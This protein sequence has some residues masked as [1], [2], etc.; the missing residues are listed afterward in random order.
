MPR[1]LCCAW[2]VLL[3]ALPAAA[4]DAKL[5][6]KPALTL[7]AEVSKQARFGQAL[8]VRLAN[9]GKVAVSVVTAKL[10]LRSDEGD[11]KLT[12]ALEMTRKEMVNSRLVVPP[13][14]SLGIVKLM[15][16]EVA[17]VTV[18]TAPKKLAKLADN[19]VVVT[20]EVSEFWGKRFGVWHGKIETTASVA[21]E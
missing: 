14:D 5:E 3:A 9:T 17:L 18:P 12:V 4:D 6:P 11:R 20:Y 1:F 7:E 10:R 2:F 15:P 16:G 8:K 19:E 21:K 13:A